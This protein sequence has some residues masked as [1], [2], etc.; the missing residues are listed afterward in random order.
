MAQFVLAPGDVEFLCS[1]DLVVS[2]LWGRVEKEPGPDRGPGVPVAFDCAGAAGGSRPP[3][4]PFP[5]P[6]WPFSP[7]T[8]AIWSA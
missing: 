1:H 7:T 3:K 4:S 8:P 2:G 6:H 5:I